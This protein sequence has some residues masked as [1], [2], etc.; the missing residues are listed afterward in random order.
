M[1]EEPKEVGICKVCGKQVKVEEGKIVG[2]LYPRGR[3]EYCVGSN[4]MPV[5]SRKESRGEQ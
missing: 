1:E 3:G 4:N 2:H 5:P